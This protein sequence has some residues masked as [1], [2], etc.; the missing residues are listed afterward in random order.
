MSQPSVDYRQR[1][2][3]LRADLQD[4]D[5]DGCVWVS[6]RFM[7]GP[8]PP[9]EGE[10]VYLLDPGG[11]GRVGQ[12]VSVHGWMGRVELEGVDAKREAVA[13]S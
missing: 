13:A 10:T 4:R 1:E 11:A 2:V 12:L 9:C 7:R 8:R 5:E 6:R 3:V